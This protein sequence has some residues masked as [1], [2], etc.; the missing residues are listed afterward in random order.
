MLKDS[1][2]TFMDFKKRLA[3]KHPYRP[4]SRQQMTTEDGAVMDW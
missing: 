3:S 2:E 4:G 1:T